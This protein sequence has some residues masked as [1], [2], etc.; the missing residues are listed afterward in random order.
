MA[1]DARSVGVSDLV[2][3]A[4][5]ANGA[6]VWQAPKGVIVSDTQPAGGVMAAGGCAIGREIRGHMVRDCA[7]Q[8]EGAL[9]GSN[10]A[11]IAVRRQGPGIIIVHVAR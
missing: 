9:P 10:V 6:M 5:T 7:S 4:I 8:R 3:V 1:I 2:Y 11:A